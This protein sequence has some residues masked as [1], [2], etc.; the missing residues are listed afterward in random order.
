MSLEKKIKNAL[1]ETRLLILG[2]QVLFGFQFQSFFQELFSELPRAT[3][4]LDCVALIMMMIPTGLLIAP[5]MQHRIIEDGQDTNRIHAATSALADAALF[6]IAIALGMDVFIAFE[7]VAGLGAGVA[8]GIVFCAL[9]LF[10]WYGVEFWLMERRVPMREEEKQTPLS[11]KV[12]QMLTEARVIIPGAQALLGFQLTVTLTRSFEQL[13]AGTRM[14][15]L[16]ALC[17]IALAIVLLMAPAAVHR[18]SFK[19]EDSTRFLKIGSFFVIAAPIPLALGIALDM[20]VA[21]TRVSEGTVLAASLCAG[22]LVVLGTLW[23]GY[24]IWRRQQL[25]AEG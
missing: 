25:R 13:A 22:T 3:Q 15:H 16:A 5:A 8:A 6:P 20:Y 24:P 17:A 18:I 2:T 1:D 19:G 21:A 12:E 7:R 14:I 4:Y 10:F 11:T 9:A 23:Y